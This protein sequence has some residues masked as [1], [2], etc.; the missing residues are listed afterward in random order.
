ML[1]H[2]RD[3]AL[4]VI[5]IHFFSR[6]SVITESG[7]H[8]QREKNQLSDEDKGIKLLTGYRAALQFGDLLDVLRRNATLLNPAVYILVRAVELVGE[9]DDGLAPLRVGRAGFEQKI[10]QRA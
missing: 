6:W 7:Y 1:L 5:W 10:M 8:N 4:L 2:E 9:A 3:Q